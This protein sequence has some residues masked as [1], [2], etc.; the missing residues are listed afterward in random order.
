[1]PKNHYLPTLNWW[2][3]LNLKS[4][5]EKEVLTSNTHSH[6]LHLKKSSHRASNFWNRKHISLTSYTSYIIQLQSFQSLKYNYLR[7]S[8]VFLIS[9][10]LAFQSSSC[11][12]WSALL[13]RPLKLFPNA[14]NPIFS[15]AHLME[16]LASHP[17]NSPH[18]SPC[19]YFA[20][21]SGWVNSGEFSRIARTASSRRRAIVSSR[22]RSRPPD[23][24]PRRPVCLM[25]MRNL[26]ITVDWRAA[27]AW[28]ETG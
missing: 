15:M 20:R 4:S 8:L 18:F 19:C 1:M 16:G 3:Y 6:D 9:E 21:R 23:A 7:Y 14:A 5:E 2:K 10:Q 11:F 13:L 26:I 22:H 17:W 27:L 28:T 12:N 25:L 24:G